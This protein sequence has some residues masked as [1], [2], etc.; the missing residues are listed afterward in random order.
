MDALT[1]DFSKYYNDII[2]ALKEVYGH[3]YGD[4]IEER[5]KSIEITT[6]ANKSGIFHYYTFLE[7][8]KSKELCIKFLNRIGIVNVNNFLS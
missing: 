2:S 3:E 8:T 1:L 7:R 6:Y 4:I 5:F